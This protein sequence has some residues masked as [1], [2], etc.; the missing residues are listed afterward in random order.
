MTSQTLP[1]YPV[2]IPSKDRSDVDRYTTMDL[3]VRDQLPFTLV[4]EEPEA[5]AYADRWPEAEI[6]VLPF[7]DQGLFVTRNWIK[8]HS[9][10]NGDKRHWQWD[11]NIRRMERMYGGK[12]I[13][14]RSGIALAVCEDFTDR[15]LNVAISGF[16][17]VMF[18][19]ETNTMPPFQANC[20]VYSC[21]LILNETP[22]RWR[23]LYNDDTDMCL[24]VLSDGWCTILLNAFLAD[25]LWTRQMKGGNTDAL[26]QGD[27]RNK[28]ARSLE[29]MWP[30]VVTVDRRYGRPQ[31]VV[32]FNWQKFDTPLI[33]DP[34]VE[35]PAGVNE[36]GMQ[37]TVRDEI[38]SPRIQAI[39]DRHKEN[40]T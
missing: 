5:D 4:V 38:K 23:V 24:Q 14:V 21:S 25:K 17:Y 31:H 39:V 22:H 19:P 29:R 28:M 11:D 34:D 16:N 27:G 26:Y 10:A 35:I 33:R 36:Y 6:L 8:D 20:H 32:A 15:Y 9:I 12:R 40:T 7:V 13:V 30:G 37:L 1:R 2:Y 3:F 18:F